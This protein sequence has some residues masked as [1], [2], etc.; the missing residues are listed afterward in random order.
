[1]KK[2]AD[3]ELRKGYTEESYLSMIAERIQELKNS[4]WSFKILYGYKNYMHGC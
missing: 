2:A 3:E 4:N 1:M